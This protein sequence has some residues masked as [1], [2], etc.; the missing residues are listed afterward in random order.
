MPIRP[1]AIVHRVRSYS[2]KGML[3]QKVENESVEVR[4]GERKLGG[5]RD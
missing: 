1:D 5:K 4:K 3:W 2:A